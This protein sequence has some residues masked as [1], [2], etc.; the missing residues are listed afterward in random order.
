MYDWKKF[1]VGDEWGKLFKA[2]SNI[3]S[4]RRLSPTVSAGSVAAAIMAGNGK[5]Y[6][7]VCIDTACSLGMCAERAAV[8]AMIADGQ[9][10]V[11]KLIC[12]DEDGKCFPP[13]GACAELLMQLGQASSECEI[14]CDYSARSVVKLKELLPRRWT[15]VSQEGSEE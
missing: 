10:V 9:S 2:A 7:G 13:C 15:D 8:A 14:M 4:S 12:I 5:I 6:T 3:C 11:K 1:F